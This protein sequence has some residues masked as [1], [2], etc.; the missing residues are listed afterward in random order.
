MTWRD[1]P[2]AKNFVWAGELIVDIMLITHVGSLSLLSSD[3]RRVF[4]SQNNQKCVGG[5]SF[6]QDSALQTRKLD[7]EE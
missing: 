6:R 7:K 3:V 5:W 2:A 1:K 4:T